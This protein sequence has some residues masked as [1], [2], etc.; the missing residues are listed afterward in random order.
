MLMYS[1]AAAA[2]FVFL[3]GFRLPE[4]I[5]EGSF[6]AGKQFIK[7]VK[8]PSRLIWSVYSV[9]RKKLPNVYKVAQKWFHWKN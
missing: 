9:T 1:K 8:P 4:A 5:R 2:L 3:S 7:P 6:E